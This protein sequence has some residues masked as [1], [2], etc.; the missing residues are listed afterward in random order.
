[1]AGGPPLELRKIALEEFF[2]KLREEEPPKLSIRIRTQDPAKLTDVAHK[3]KT[4]PVALARQVR[5]DLDSILNGLV[6][7]IGMDFYPTRL[8]SKTSQWNR[9][10]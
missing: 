10:N 6:E 1:L 4:E 3:R 8:R 5:G 2:R 7:V 9:Q